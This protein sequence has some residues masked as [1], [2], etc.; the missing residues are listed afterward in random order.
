MKYS[1]P[2]GIAACLALIISCFLPWTYIQSVNITITGVESGNTN[3]GKPGLIH[4]FFS[5]AAIVFFVINK[6]WS[7]RT[8]LI[9][10]TLN[11]A[12]ALRNFLLMSRCELGECPERKVG[13]FL[14][15]LFAFVIFVMSLLPKIDLNK[16]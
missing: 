3:F 15:L 2:V 13:I 11:F 9:L 16:E 8:L 5:G 7:K 10:T 6:I 14:V 12:W 1:S 4:I